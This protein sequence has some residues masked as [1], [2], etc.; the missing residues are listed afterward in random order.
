MNNVLACIA[1]ILANIPC[2]LFIADTF[3]SSD[4]EDF[5]MR[6]NWEQLQ[7]DCIKEETKESSRKQMMWNASLGTQNC[8]LWKLWLH[9]SLFYCPLLHFYFV[10]FI[11]SSSSSSS[12]VME[13]YSPLIIWR[14]VNKSIKNFPLTDRNRKTSK[15]Q[16]SKL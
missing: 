9:K 15:N 14:S 2:N 1:I 16:L 6:D 3:Y 8:T 7:K 13:S 10:A 12:I 5:T 11:L 4:D